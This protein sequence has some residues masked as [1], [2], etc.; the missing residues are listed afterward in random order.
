MINRNLTH[1]DIIKQDAM[2]GTLT[3]RK[4]SLTQIIHN[5]IREH[6]SY[7]DGTFD[8]DVDELPISDKRLLL[9]HFEAAEWYEY[10][11]ESELKTNALF[12]ESAKYIQQLI[13]DECYEVYRD[14]MEEMR[15]Y[16]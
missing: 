4:F 8:L 5:L 14:V 10:A 3:K 13:D 16:K 2:V 12:S 1:V 6:G 15:A 11:C 7:K 9:S